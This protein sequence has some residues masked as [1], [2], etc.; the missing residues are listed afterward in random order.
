MLASSPLTSRLS[1]ALPQS[2]AN[3]LGNNHQNNNPRGFLCWVVGFYM[4]GQQDTPSPNVDTTMREALMR[5]NI[6]GRRGCGCMVGKLML[7]VGV[8]FLPMWLGAAR[9]RRL[10]LPEILLWTTASQHP[11]E[12]QTSECSDLLSRSR[13]TL[14]IV[15]QRQPGKLSSS[16]GNRNAPMHSSL[17]CGIH[18]DI[19]EGTSRRNICSRVGQI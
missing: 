18:G 9:V 4:L 7:M 10:P 11:S 13:A 1:I 2:V 19:R 6:T 17:T 3:P 5:P 8:R 16:L 15:A 14:V 12:S